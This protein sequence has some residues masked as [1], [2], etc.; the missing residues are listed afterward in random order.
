M[1]AKIDELLGKPCWLVDIFPRRAPRRDDGR[2]FKV[3]EIFR[4]NR[5]ELNEKLDE[6]FCRLL[7]KLYCYYDFCCVFGEERA[8]NP[9]PELLAEWLDRCLAGGER[10]AVL[11]PACDALICLDGGDLYANVYNPDEEFCGLLAQLAA[12]EGLFFRKS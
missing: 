5:W 10:F 8:E 2:Y 9:E 11:L 12:A 3:E 4:R 7:L 6:N 1:I